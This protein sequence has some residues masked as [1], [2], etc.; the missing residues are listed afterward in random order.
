MP[1][2]KAKAA[3]YC[4]YHSMSEL[5]VLNGNVCAMW[6]RES[7]TAVSYTSS[8]WIHEFRRNHCAISLTRSSVRGCCDRPRIAMKRF[9][10]FLLHVRYM[11]PGEHLRE[12][13]SVVKLP[14]RRALYE[15]ASQR[16]ISLC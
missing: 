5:N 7:L 8:N 9:R 1:A 11:Q 3:F 6:T 13:H 2:L 4:T 16:R 12:T 15:A 14:S 10:D